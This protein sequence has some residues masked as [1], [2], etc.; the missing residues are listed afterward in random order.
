MAS[1]GRKGDYAGIA[2]RGAAIVIDMVVVTVG[3]LTINWLISL[4]ISFF[5]S[6]SIPQCAAQSSGE[7]STLYLACR[8]VSIAWVVIPLVAAPLYFIFFFWTSGQTV[9]KYIMGLRVVRLD[10]APMTLLTATARWF[11]YFVS[12]LS[13][14]VGFLWVTV[15]S[16]RLAFHDYLA[17]TCVI[18]SWQAREDRFTLERARNWFHRGWRAR[19]FGSASGGP[20]TALTG[21]THTEEATGGHNA[22]AVSVKSYGELTPILDRL[23]A[24]VGSGQIAILSVMVLAKDAEGDIGLVGATALDASGRYTGLPG[25]GQD[26]HTA[27]VERIKRELPADRFIVLVMLAARFAEKLTREV[28]P[29]TAGLIGRY[30]LGDDP[31]LPSLIGPAPL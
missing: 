18:Y 14:G 13:L 10:G 15:D 19:L 23:Q 25:L 11:G 12:T 3:V 22:I 20:S 29:V 1:S 8:A 21:G 26:I 7:R 9:G 4:P 17:H 6:T 30:D 5:F 24:L 16:R 27:Q 2:S 28:R 31:G